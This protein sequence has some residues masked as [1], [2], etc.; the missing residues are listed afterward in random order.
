M[1]LTYTKV[2][3]YLLPNLTIKNQNYKRINKYR[4][5]KLQY[6]KRN[7]KTFYTTLLMKNELTNYLVSVSNECENKSNNLMEQFK[8]SDKLLSEK[9]KEINQLEWTKLMNNYNN[10]AEEII[11][12]ELIYNKNVW[13]QTIIFVLASTE[14]VLPHKFYYGK[15]LSPY[16]ER[17]KLIMRKRNIKI[18]VFLNEMEKIMLVEKSNKARLSQSDFIRKLIND[19]ANDDETKSNLEEERVQLLKIIENLSLL[20]RQMDFLGYRDYSNLIIKQINQIKNIL[21]DY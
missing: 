20:K 21:N 19:Y 5:L 11:L 17:I 1:K 8:K 2:G 15:F 9:S 13:V 14:F 10:I 3:D 12:N 4:L 18:N 16:F 7:N 6:L